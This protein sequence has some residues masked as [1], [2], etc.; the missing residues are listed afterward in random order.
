MFNGHFYHATMRKSVAVFGTLFNNISVIRK[1]GNGNVLNQIKVP[2]AYGPK[3]KFLARIENP[4]NKNASMAIKLPRMSFEITGITIDSASKLPKRSSI[5][6]AGTSTSKKNVIKNMVSYD[7]GMQLNIMA[8]NQDDGLQ[9]LEQIL[10]YF[11]PEYNVS[12]RPVD[13]FDFTQDVPVVLNSASIADEYEGDFVSRRVLVYTLDFTMKMKF[14]GPTNEENIIRTVDVTLNDSEQQEVFYENVN[15]VPD[16]SNTA[17]VTNEDFDISTTIDPLYVPET[18]T[19][20][21]NPDTG[22]FTVGE[23]I[24]GSDSASEATISVITGNIITVV[25]PDGYFHQNENITG[26]TDGAVATVI[27]AG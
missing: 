8:K 25:N 24:L 20:N 14:Y 15:T 13:G 12:I 4:T 21:S 17:P 1:D 18:F 22:T 23:K 26:Q 5:S 2:L 27:S 10:P 16:P 6:E 19:I 7:I 3:Q 9:I 11:Q